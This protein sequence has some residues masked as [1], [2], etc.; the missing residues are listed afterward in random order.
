MDFTTHFLQRLAALAQRNTFEFPPDTLPEH[1]NKAVVLLPFWPDGLGGVKLL[2]TR[3]AETMSS[4]AG[5]VS[6]PGGRVDDSD[7]SLVHA[8]LR[9]NKEEL[10]IDPAQVKIMG[11]LDDAF[12]L[13]GHHVVP[14]V[15][16]LEMRPEIRPNKHEVAEVLIADVEVLLRP[17]T[18]CQHQIERGKIT[19][20]THAFRWDTA[21]VWGL[22]ADLLLELLL[23]VQDKPTNRGER[24]PAQLEQMQAWSLKSA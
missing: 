20:T 6:F 10:G 19:R 8:V 14:F 4:H 15:G 11:R 13:A 18:S 22:T 5:Q 17:E 3:R 1:H 16:W 2:L 24:R 21:Y 23:W 7:A 9:E 12:S